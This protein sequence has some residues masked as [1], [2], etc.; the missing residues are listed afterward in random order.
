[1]LRY[2]LAAALAAPVMAL[3]QVP[4]GLAGIPENCEAPLAHDMEMSA[5]PQLLHIPETGAQ[6]Q[7]IATIGNSHA[8]SI[9]HNAERID[10]KI[11]VY[12]DNGTIDRNYKFSVWQDRYGR[13]QGSYEP[14]QAKATAVP[15]T[16]QNTDAQPA[17]A[18]DNSSWSGIPPLPPGASETQT[19]KSQAHCGVTDATGHDVTRWMSSSDCQAWIKEA[20]ELSKSGPSRLEI[21]T[22]CQLKGVAFKQAA[23]YRD[24]GRSPQTTLQLL[25]NLEPSGL[26]ES[27]LKNTINLVYFDSQFADA[28]G[29][30]L[31]DQVAYLCTHPNPPSYMPLQ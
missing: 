22:Q 4:P 12:W 10:C 3:A 19:D 28:G 20:Q 21:F 16:K 25:K 6:I 27:F 14:T 9:E 31:A 5:I 1:M 15:Q 13:F 7:K 18:T 2:L 8:Y 26:S 30:R 23:E 17:L 24:S 11:S 29:Q